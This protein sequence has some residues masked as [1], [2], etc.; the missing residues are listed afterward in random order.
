METARSDTGDTAH[1]PV[2]AT[3]LRQDH[4]SHLVALAFTAGLQLDSSSGEMA[5][6]FD[7]LHGDMNGHQGC[8]KGLCEEKVLST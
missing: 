7:L 6:P 2:G 4:V 1:A 8:F 3:L 5:A